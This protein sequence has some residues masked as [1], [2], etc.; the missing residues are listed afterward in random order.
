MVYLER[1]KDGAAALE[2]A[3]LFRITNSAESQF[4]VFGAETVGAERAS[5]ADAMEAA[6]RFLRQT[7]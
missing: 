3:V 6:A 4:K 5:L 2:Y 1:K 7:E